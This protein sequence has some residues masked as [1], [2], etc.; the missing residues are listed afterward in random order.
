MEK[1][2]ELDKYRWSVGL[3][4]VEGEEDDWVTIGN[5]THLHS[6]H[7]AII[8]HHLQDDGFLQAAPCQED[9]FES[10][11]KR[12]VCKFGKILSNVDNVV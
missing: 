5:V 3:R 12:P 4:Q 7:C 2:R 8:N 11:P 9:S 1:S 6:G 10:L